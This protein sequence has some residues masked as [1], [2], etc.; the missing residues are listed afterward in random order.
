MYKIGLRGNLPKFICNFLSHRTFQVL[1]GTTLSDTFTQEEGVPQGAILSTTLFNLKINDIAKE[2]NPGMDCSL[3]VDDF[4]I[5]YRSKR[6]ALIERQVQGQINK[7]QK[8]TTNNGFSFSIIKTRAMHFVPPYLHPKY[9]E[10]DPELYLNGHRIKVVAQTKFLGLIWDSK[11]NFRPHID[12]LK[13]KCLKAINILKVVAHY[14]W[15]A[16]ERTLLHLYRTLVRS[17]LDFGCMVYGSACKTYIKQLDVVQNQ[18]LRLCLGAFRSSPVS[19]LYVEANEPPLHFRRQHP[20]T[21]F[22]SSANKKK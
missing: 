20:T 6:M 8:W 16:D 12:Y 1:L 17:K 22:P 2:L 21:V 13:K 4:S 5:C 15:G 14:D 18:A 11:L 19:S 10:P 7:L 3:Y 9:Q